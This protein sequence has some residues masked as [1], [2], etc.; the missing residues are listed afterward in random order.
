MSPTLT[1]IDRDGAAR[2]L[3]YH[4]HGSHSA[5]SKSSSPA[6][7]MITLIGSPVEKCSNALFTSSSMYLRVWVG[8]E[9]CRI[10]TGG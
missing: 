9:Y 3:A 7:L 1:A 6:G 4:S 10:R 8:Y 2:S 5:P